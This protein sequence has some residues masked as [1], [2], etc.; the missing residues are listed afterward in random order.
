MERL[1]PNRPLPPHHQQVVLLPIPQHSCPTVCLLRGTISPAAGRYSGRPRQRVRVELR[2]A[3]MIAAV[4]PAISTEEYDAIAEGATGVSDH[5]QVGVP[6]RGAVL[7]LS[8][9]EVEY[10]D[11]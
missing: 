5:A 1:E 8:C 6:P 10:V 11:V 4:V 7:P 3:V 2:D 9:P